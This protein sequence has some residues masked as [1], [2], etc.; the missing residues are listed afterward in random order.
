MKILKFILGII[1]TIAI[2][3]CIFFMVDKNRVEEGKAPQF[4]IKKVENEGNKI[5][6]TGLGYKV[7]T[8]P[9]DKENIEESL[10]DKKRT[11]IGSYFMNFEIK[12]D[13]IVKDDKDNTENMEIKNVEDFY[14]Y[15]KKEGQEL[16]KANENFSAEDAKQQDFYVITNKD[17][18]LNKE[19]LEEFLN[20]Y[21]E[22]K[23]AVLR[24]AE[25][26]KE[27]RI[28]I[29]DIL[30]EP[31]T[32]KVYVAADKSRD[33]ELSE[34]ETK[35][36]LEVYDKIEKVKDEENSKEN[37]VVFEGEEYDAKSD[38]KKSMVIGEVK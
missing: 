1:I 31:K 37:L 7:I 34:D 6:Y 35:L 15:I 27:G 25:E 18:N 5:T 3:G 38:A 16:K 36:K 8:Y 20:K 4:A 13:K 22:N 12:E 30:F 17:E 11:K 33:K 21:K 14:N 2:I 28:Y 29:F 32:K 19:K 26:T 24:I 23:M 9:K 10:K